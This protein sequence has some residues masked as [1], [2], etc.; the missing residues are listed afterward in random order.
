M[1]NGYSSLALLRLALFYDERLISWLLTKLCT[2]FF[3]FFLIE[4]YICEEG[5]S[6]FLLVKSPIELFNWF[7]NLNVVLEFT[8]EVVD[9]VLSSLYLLT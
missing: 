6:F 5:A 1:S 9:S 7:F 2:L 3:D 8:I 4:L